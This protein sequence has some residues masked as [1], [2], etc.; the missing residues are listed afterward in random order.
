MGG[1][2]AKFYAIEPEVAGGLGS[3]TVSN[4]AN[5]HLVISRLHYELDGWLGDHLLETTP[6]FIATKELADRLAEAG[7]SGFATDR[8][9]VTTSEQFR[10]L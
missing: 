3:G 2:M 8:V 6:C 5:G 4:R 9:D 1:A 10:D 7:L